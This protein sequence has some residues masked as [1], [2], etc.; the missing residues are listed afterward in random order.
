MMSLENQE[1]AVRMVERLVG[2]GLAM[3]ADERGCSTV[4]WDECSSKV[5]WSID[6]EELWAVS[7]WRVYTL[8]NICHK[9]ESNRRLTAQFACHS[10]TT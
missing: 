9:G 10:M 6:M 7:T 4:W 2:E 8:T 3:L 1:G 5:C